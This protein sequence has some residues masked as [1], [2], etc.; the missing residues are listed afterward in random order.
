M[1]P[2]TEAAWLESE[3]PRSSVGATLVSPALVHV[4]LGEVNARDKWDLLHF[5]AG[6]I[7][8]MRETA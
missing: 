6:V 1:I 2:D 3:V 5:F 4:E 7:G 8:S